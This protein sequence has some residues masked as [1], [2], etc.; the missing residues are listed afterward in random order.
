MV[1]SG[2]L[3]FLAL[4]DFEDSVSLVQFPDPFSVLDPSEVN[5]VQVEFLVAFLWR[6]LKTLTVF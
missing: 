1:I 5:L 6:P 2:D 4:V 3:E